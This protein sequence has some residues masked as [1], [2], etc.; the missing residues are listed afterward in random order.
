MNKFSI[1]Q[2]RYKHS[3]AG[4]QCILLSLDTPQSVLVSEAQNNITLNRSGFMKTVFS[5]GDISVYV[6]VSVPQYGDLSVLPCGDISVLPYE[7]Q[8]DY[9]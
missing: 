1:F 9:P 8:S 6:W 3:I 7:D 5:Y 2:F 4:R